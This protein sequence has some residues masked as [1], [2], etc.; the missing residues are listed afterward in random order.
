MGDSDQELLRRFAK[1]SDE[2]AFEALLQR[3]VD[4]V[5][6]AALRQAGPD[7]QA[8]QDIAQ[9]VFIDLARKAPQ[10]HGHATLTG[11]LYTAVRNAATAHRRTEA[12]RT[13]REQTALSMNPADS[14]PGPEP[15]WNRLRPLLD[16]AM[17]ALS[18]DDS[19]AVLL[20]CFE[21]RAYSEIGMRLGVAE[22]AARMR[23][24]RALDRLG[25]LLTRRG[26]TST[27]AGLA[28]VLETHAVT[29]TPPTIAEGIARGACGAVRPS[30]GPSVISMPL[31]LGWSWA[32]ALLLIVGIGGLMWL[33]RWTD[34]NNPNSTRADPATQTVPASG[35]LNLGSNSA[36]EGAQSGGISST[37]TTNGA[38]GS[39]TLNN[40][41]GL[42]LTFVTKD[43]G[44]PVPNV[45]VSYRGAE[46]NHFTQ[47]E[48]KAS[49]KGEAKI[50]IVPGTTHLTLQ[51]VL[52]G[53]ADTRLTWDP[54]KGNPI[55][56]QRT[57]RL[58]RA[59]LIGGTVLDPNGNP[60]PGAT[61]LWG[62]SGR[63]VLNTSGESREFGTVETT[64]DMLGQ[65]RLHR[66][67]A[68]MLP[69]IWG[70]ATHPEFQP[71]ETVGHVG[72]PGLNRDAFER[73]LQ[74][75][76]HV[77]RLKTASE[78]EGVVV[79]EGGAPIAGARVRVGPRDMIASRE[80]LTD[81]DGRFRVHGGP[82]GST[83][84][85][86]EAQ[87]FAAK[88][89]PVTLKERNDPVRIALAK[90]IPLRIR[91]V[92]S[93]GTP[94]PNAYVLLNIMQPS[95]DGTLSTP[96]QASFEAF[97]DTE[98][99]VVW[100]NAPAG[101][102]EFRITVTGFMARNG[103]RV[104]A[105]DQE[106]DIVLNP[107]LVL[108]GTVTDA[109]SGEPIPSFRLAL[110][111]TL[112][113]PR[114]GKTHIQVS[115]LDQLS[116]TFSGGRFRHVLGEPV[117]DGMD[118]PKLI[119]RFEADGYQRV[120]SR[121]I[122]YD[123]GVV[124]LDVSLQRT[125]TLEVTVVD[126]AG[127][128]APG[129][130]IGL[131]P[132]GT[133]VFLGPNGLM[134][135]PG[136]EGFRAI[137]QADEEGRVKL[138][139][140]DLTVGKIVAAGSR[141][142]LG[143]SET[144]WAR[145]QSDTVLPLVPWGRIRGQVLGNPGALKGKVLLLNKQQEDLSGVTLDF[146][147]QTDSEGRFEFSKVPAGPIRVVELIVEQSGQIYESRSVVVTVKPDEVLEVTLGGRTRVSGQLTPPAGFLP[148]PDGSWYVVLM[149]SGQPTPPAGGRLLAP[150][151]PRAEQYAGFLPAIVDPAGA[152]AIDAVEPGTYELQAKWIRRP[153]P[154][155]ISAFTPGLL[156]LPKPITVTVP[157]ESG[158]IDLGEIQLK[159]TATKVTSPP[160]K[161]VL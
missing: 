64:T 101:T 76:K 6:S 30:G 112:F 2:S 16:E 141:G 159:A 126:A 115:G 9:S 131:M 93:N 78:L 150:A 98:G 120:I 15:D 106:H 110:G 55:P 43:A 85:T 91:V 104:P 119:V 121:A 134:S 138:Q 67:A 82:I 18:D 136:S 109:G 155:Q 111:W 147:T 116:P 160:K 71:S 21:R 59:I 39:G 114:L 52:E 130:S 148:Q 65:W 80:I 123:E 128:P 117:M 1:D 127:Q 122:R 156:E 145:L 61:V 34:R 142:T 4:L 81:S 108:Q 50:S 73:E 56:K 87:G 133:Q 151:S 149:G 152:F 28:L 161:L 132:P 77:F 139:K 23:V 86:A 143:F 102:H 8:A 7:P 97:S 72:Q 57:V 107:A 89:L 144:S 22:N 105:D 95:V 69:L 103:V 60:A 45:T 153:S 135:Q 13:Q 157:P 19:E 146:R 53:F 158:P 10:L 62:H 24:E 84:L 137:H 32:V 42:L 36:A 33:N 70:W 100:E 68:S 99:R 83:V 38:V 26:I 46:G 31:R 20:R 129:A 154:G 124:T 49:A 35:S 90:G 113:D 5:H 25:E 40:G 96:P 17:H 11:W 58:E 118:D 88:T 74:D 47:A 48:F 41:P 79:N 37:D 92:G 54:D 140:K 12:R 29:A 27:A 75:L 125:E 3:H 63:S 94:V 14:T 66:I 51:C 44:E